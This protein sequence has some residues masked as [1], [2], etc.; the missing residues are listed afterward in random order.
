VNFDQR[1]LFFPGAK[2]IEECIF[3]LVLILIGENKR[4][5]AK[6]IGQISN[7]PVISI[8]R[9]TVNSCRCLVGKTDAIII[10]N[11]SKTNNNQT[12]S[13][14]DEITPINLCVFVYP[15]LVKNPAVDFVANHQ[16]S[17]FSTCQ[18][19]KLQVILGKGISVVAYFNA[20]KK[21]FVKR[22]NYSS[23]RIVQYI[24]P[25]KL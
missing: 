15:S 6:Q 23:F 11:R 18:S 4:L 20:T 7:S 9:Y 25:Y 8:D 13:A 12:Q 24:V 22:E 19:R 21:F 1:F 5:H 14:D 17:V 10:E 3:C 16:S 2:G